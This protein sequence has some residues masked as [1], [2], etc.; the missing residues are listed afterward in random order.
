MR[1]RRLAAG[2]RVAISRGN[3]SASR[4]WRVRSACAEARECMA[5]CNTVANIAM[6]LAS[7]KYVIDGIGCVR[8]G[9]LVLKAA[10]IVSAGKS[11]SDSVDRILQAQSDCLRSCWD[12]PL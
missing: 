4:V 11:Y 2:R 1:H 8:S 10:C 5:C 9:H 7:A 12:N 3:E 6:G